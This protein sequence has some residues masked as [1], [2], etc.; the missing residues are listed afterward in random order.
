MN[1]SF[2]YEN[3]LQAQEAGIDLILR[4]TTN[5]TLSDELI[6]G[7][8]H[9]LAQVLRN[10]LS[11]ALKF[12]PTSGSVTVDANCVT[13]DSVGGVGGHRVVRVSVTD[14]GAGISPVIVQELRRHVSSHL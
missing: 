4:F 8:F 9:K 14:S 6:N 2:D 1:C 7:D 13:A 5:S 10:V 12:T 3:V 11:N